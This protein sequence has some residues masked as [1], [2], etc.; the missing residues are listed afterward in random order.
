MKSALISSNDSDRLILLFAGWGMDS[1]PFVSLRRPGYDIAVVWDYRDLT[2]DASLTAPYREVCVVAWSLGVV[3][4]GIL[5]PQ[6]GSKVTRFLAVNGTFT[7]IDDERG[8]PQAVFNGTHDGLDERSLRKFYRR[9][10]GSA[11]LFAAFAATMPERPVDELKEELRSF[12]GRTVP[13]DVRMPDLAVAGM[14]DAIFPP[15]NQ[16][17]AWENIP[18]VRTDDT[19][20]PDFSALL[21]TY[22][23]DKDIMSKRFGQRR[24]SYDGAAEV[25]SAIV[26]RLMQALSECG[27]LSRAADV[28]EVGCGTGLLSRRIDREL[29]PEAQF[30][31]WDIVGESPLSGPRR[32]FCCCDAELAVHDLPADSLDLICSA[33]TVQWF[34]S[35][36]AF[37]KECKRVLRPGGVLA[38]STFCRGNIAEVE[39]STGVALPVFTADE[40]IASLPAGMRE[41]FRQE[42]SDTLIF[43]TPAEV[44]RHLSRTGVNSL[45]ASDSGAV[46]RRALKTYPLDCEGRAPL[47]Y[48]SIIFLFVKE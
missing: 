13:G 17:K 45:A 5:M 18:V 6:I 30:T 24:S 20:L 43:D 19:H 1:R 15:A 28:L 27:I 34:N 2:F 8:I 9:M 38:V 3:A 46:L 32:S 26:G 48:R 4:A 41:I 11:S 22:I 36:A 23:I 21:D 33:S 39:Q 35:P 40:W 16:L 47:T 25:Q 12:V 7:P 31:L 44:F 29:S 42:C 10:A 37:F 14:N